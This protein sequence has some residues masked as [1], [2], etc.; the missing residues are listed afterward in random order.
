[1]NARE[2]LLHYGIAF[3]DFV[4]HLLGVFADESAKNKGHNN[5]RWDHTHD[6]QCQL[7][8]GEGQNGDAPNDHAQSTQEFSQ[9]RGQGFPN[10]RGIRSH[11]RVQ[12][13]HSFRGEERH[14]QMQQVGIKVAADGRQ[15]PFSYH[16]KQHY[17]EESRHTLNG[18]QAHHLQHVVAQIIRRG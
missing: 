1:M 15:G 11:S 6:E 18:Q 16:H 14:G 7:D 17:S 13:P 2:G 12:L 10:L 4:L 5:E 9:G 8:G 3:G